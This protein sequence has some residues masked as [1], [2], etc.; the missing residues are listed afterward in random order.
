MLA[1]SS[2]NL[3]V[4]LVCVVL[5]LKRARLNPLGFLGKS[6][7]RFSK[8]WEEEGATGNVNMCSAWTHVV[9]D[10]LRSVTV[11]A[12]SIV[13]TTH[14]ELD[15]AQVDSVAALVVSGI[16]FVITVPLVYA[17]WNKYRVLLDLWHD[18]NHAAE[19]EEYEKFIKTTK[20]TTSAVSRRHEDRV[21]PT[22]D[23]ADDD[24]FKIANTAAA[25]AN[26]NAT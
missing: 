10:T 23:V 15:S 21:F 8:G 26:A 3:T 18:R 16:I 14:P 24:L 7:S 9:A 2:V 25:N 6:S 17:A 13:V 5:F 19:P 4:D 12:A 20:T 11:L 1:F 22:I